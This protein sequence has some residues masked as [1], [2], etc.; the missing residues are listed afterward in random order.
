[1]Q[2]PLN[3][4]CYAFCRLLP[5]HRIRAR[6]DRCGGTDTLRV[7][8]DDVISPGQDNSSPLYYR[9]RY[10]TYMNKS[11]LNAMSPIPASMP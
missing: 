10:E 8:P 1:V 3:H 9:G 6:I 2:I 5:H 11:R 7:Y 4:C